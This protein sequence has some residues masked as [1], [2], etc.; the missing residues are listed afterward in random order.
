MSEYDYKALMYR[1]IDEAWNK[2][3]LE[4]LDEAIADSFVYHD[5]LMPDIVGV[6]GYKK[7]ITEVRA[8]YPDFQM[9]IDELIQEGNTLSG[10]L[11][12]EGS[13]LGASP[14]LKIPATGKRVAAT[15][16]FV[17]H[18]KDGKTV[19]QWTFQDWVGIMRQL[20]LMPAQ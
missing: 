8:S 9:T 3:E 14:G 18:M 19:E 17:T 13:Q 7:Y 12:W 16:A 10:R 1:V 6:E 20:G 11:H 15:A 4:V 2:G 5:L